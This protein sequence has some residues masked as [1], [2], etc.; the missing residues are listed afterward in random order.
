[1]NTK[2]EQRLKNIKRIT[3]PH[4]FKGN[5]K[6]TK[7]TE[8]KAINENE[9]EFKIFISHKKQG[10][11]QSLIGHST[12]SLTATIE[13]YPFR[14]IINAIGIFRHPLKGDIPV[15]ISEINL[16][17]SEEINIFEP[18]PDNISFKKIPQRIPLKKYY[19]K[20]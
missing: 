4:L 10:P 5:E 17:P 15:V 3:E 7:I 20:K 19:K 13:L 1:M 2:N 8:I 6:Q 9:Y 18:L 12:T 16:K 14:I 11:Q